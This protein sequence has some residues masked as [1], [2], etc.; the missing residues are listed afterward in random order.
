MV[1]VIATEADAA[2][3]PASANLKVESAADPGRAA[4]GQ[5]SAVLVMKS[6][7]GKALIATLRNA[8]GR[9]AEELAGRRKVVAYEAT[10]FLGLDNEAIYS[11]EPAAGSDEPG[12]EPTKHW[13]QRKPA[14]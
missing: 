5:P 10:G 1:R 12:S 11:D 8:E 4:L 6:G 13:W 14:K 9:Q 7:E 2:A 3:L